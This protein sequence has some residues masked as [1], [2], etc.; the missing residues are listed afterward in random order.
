M[1]DT[2][3]DPAFHFLVQ[4]R[5]G[6]EFWQNVVVRGSAVEAAREKLK[7]YFEG[8]GVVLLSF[9]EEETKEAEVAAISPGWLKNRVES[10]GIIAMGGRIWVDPNLERS[11]SILER[12][13]AR[14]IGRSPRN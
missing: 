3:N 12:L 6:L 14:F 13:F 1:N 4:G 2:E 5:D 10:C 11:P 8:L 7:T 9:D